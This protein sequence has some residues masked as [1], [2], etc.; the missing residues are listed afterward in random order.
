MAA[1]WVLLV[2][3]VASAAVSGSS[4]VHLDQSGTSLAPGNVAVDIAA[5][6]P[7]TVDLGPL[8]EGTDVTAYASFGPVAVFAVGHTTVLPGGVTVRPRDLVQWDGATYQIALDGEGSGI[9]D[10]VAIDSFAVD[11]LSGD[12]W[13][14][15]DAPVLFAG[16]LVRAGD[17][18]D[19]VTG[20][21]AFDSAAVGVPPGTNLDAASMVPGSSDILLSFDVGGTLGGVTYADEDVLRYDPVANAWSLEV[22]TSL[23]QPSWAAAD[24]DSLELLP[25][26]EHLAALIAGSFL[27]A[28][29]RSARR[30]RRAGDS[31]AHPRRVHR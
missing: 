10:G 18:L 19:G 30:F 13:L 22:D 16:Q 5:A 25:E 7:G 14:S 31:V 23:A 3:G 2:A 6:A 20:T 8:P 12:L 4:D 24:L 15:F 29:L 28:G 26:P 9:P 17:L 21:L 27:L 1:V 11:A